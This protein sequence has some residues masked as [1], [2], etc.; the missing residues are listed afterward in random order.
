[1]TGKKPPSPPAD[2]VNLNVRSMSF[3]LSSPASPGR[4]IL[5]GVRICSGLELR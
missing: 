3:P 5:V 2:S 1:M 4:L